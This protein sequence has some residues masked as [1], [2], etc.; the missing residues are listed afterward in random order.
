MLSLVGHNLGFGRPRGHREG[1]WKGLGW[2]IGVLGFGDGC[3]N[4][5]GVHLTA[6]VGYVV[7]IMFLHAHLKEPRIVN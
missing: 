4:Y 2:L 7:Q 1:V 5:P 6:F 3:P